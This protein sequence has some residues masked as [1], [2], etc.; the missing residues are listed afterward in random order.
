MHIVVTGASSGIGEAVAREL[1]RPGT[2]L[3]LVARRR[4]RLEALATELTSLGAE[5]RVVEHDLSK[6]AEATAWLPATLAAFGPVDVLI[7][8]A[9]V[10]I[11][12]STAETDNDAA[13]ALL[14]TNL[15]SP[16][17]LTR[18]LLPSM[19]ARGAGT[20]VDVASVAALAPTPG[21]TWYNASKAGLAA[22]SES[23]RG[24]LRG[25]GVHVV[26]VY[27]GI[28]DTAMSDAAIERAEPSR[29]LALQ[30]H[31]KADEL[32]RRIHRAITKRTD[33]VIFPRSMS[34]TRRFPALTRWFLDRYTP[35]FLPLP[36]Q[37]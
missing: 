35:R 29:M 32:A 34:L 31:G 8:N 14:A 15:L 11:V 6:P 7:N 20:V 36:Q 27:P 10:Q 26:T 24:E 37:P 28:I 13:D 23:L 16:L 30:P 17:R 21:M 18:A 9:G 22:A 2:R 5:V 4:A 1:A 33:R 3:T 12:G 19:L 25:T